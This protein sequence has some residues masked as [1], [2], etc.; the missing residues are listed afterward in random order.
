MPSSAAVLTAEVETSTITAVV[1]DLSMYGKSHTFK[2]ETFK[3]PTNCDLCGDRIWGLSAKG[4]I[5]NDCGFTCHSKCQLKVPAECPG[6]QTKEEKK[7]LKVERQA[8]ATAAVEAPERVV[9]NGSCHRVAYHFD[10]AGYNELAVFRV[11][12]QVL[13]APFLESYRNQRL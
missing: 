2:S 8:A 13:H 4:F 5:C 11:T 9:A 6:E 7:R 1:G 3:I 10:K 12:L